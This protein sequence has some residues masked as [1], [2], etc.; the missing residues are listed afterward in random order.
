MNLKIIGA[1]VAGLGVGGAGG[2]FAARKL[3]Q[4]KNDK[5]LQDAIDQSSAAYRKDLADLKQRFEA[6]KE[7]LALASEYESHSEDPVE[8]E[9]FEKDLEPIEAPAP[10]EKENEEMDIY[11]IGI[12]DFMQDADYDK[13]YIT[14]YRGDDMLVNESEEEIDRYDALG[15]M[16]ELL[17]DYTGSIMYIRNEREKADYQVDFADGEF[18]GGDT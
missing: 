3:L 5:I 17:P 14:Y 12:A 1:F 11:A 18:S 2:Y 6:E 13:K 9:D 4:K 10:E 7:A 8:P 16:G 15:D